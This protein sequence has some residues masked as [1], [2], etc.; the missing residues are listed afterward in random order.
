M[1]KKVFL[2]RIFHREKPRIFIDYDYDQV[3]D[4]IVRSLHGR[5]YS[6]THKQWYVDDTEESVKEILLAFKEKADV[7]ISAL[8]SSFNRHLVAGQE[9]DLPPEH[10]QVTIVK[11]SPPEADIPEEFDTGS[12]EPE[13]T[14]AVTT[15]YGPVE[16]RISDADGR[17]SIRFRGRYKREWIDE[18]RSYGKFYYDKIHKEFLLVWSQLKVDSLSDYFDSEGVEVKVIKP[19][20]SED[21]KGQR[22]AF[23]DEVRSRILTPE[24]VKAVD[25]LRCYLEENRYSI[26]TSESYI[27]LLG[28]FF[29][30]YNEKD[31]SEITQNEVSDFMNSFIV[32][33][34]F[35][36]SY[37]NQMI[38]AIKTYYEISGKGKVVPQIM[39]R[40]RRGRALPKVFSKE[41]ITR[42]LNSARNLKHRLLLWMIY[43]CGLRRSEAT[44]IK[45]TDLDRDRGI[46][47]IREGKGRIDR[48]VPVSDKVWVKLDEYISG[49]RPEKYL[50]EGQNGGKYSVESVYNVF[51]QALKRAGIN[52][53]VGVH[54]LRHSYATHLHENGLDIK[55]IQELLGHRSSKTTEI[56]TH[57]S[58]RNLI[59]VR[60]PIEDLD[61]G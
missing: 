21:L 3:T 2:K 11:K 29:R 15:G 33:L 6:N 49:Y 38:S 44:N 13:L 26:R 22:K 61:I 53:E 31:P 23:S 57:V 10:S 4:G 54:S 24:A 30:Y 59:A 16:F 42:I 46:L 40:P 35:S 28:L 36:S 14:K 58:R 47:H 27:S 52:K 34:G 56:Y 17:L 19:V 37:Q 41:E 32:K 55:Y 8:S 60:S 39:E 12:I 5:A 7:D 1:K 9:T 20:V 18:I 43:S 45:L 50:F 25:L 51:K 48:I